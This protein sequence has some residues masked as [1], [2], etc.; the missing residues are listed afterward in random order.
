MAKLAKFIFLI[1]YIFSGWF[2]LKEFADN[3]ITVTEKLKF[4]LGRADLQNILGKGENN[5]QHF[6]LL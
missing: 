1:L 6:L 4:V 3:K 2:E 5:Y